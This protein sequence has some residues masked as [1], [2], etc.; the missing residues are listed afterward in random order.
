MQRV[1]LLPQHPLPVK[2]AFFARHGES[3]YSAREL[4]NG[5][6]ARRRSGSPTPASSRRARLGEVLRAEPLD[7]CITTELERVRLT[8][9][10]ALGG[11]DVPRLV[12]ARAERPALRPVR[13]AHD[14]GV[15]GVGDGR[16]VVGDARRR[17]RE[18]VRDRRALRARLPRRARPARG[19]DPRRRA[20][21]ADLVPARRAAKASSRARGRR[22][23]R[24]RP[25]TASRPRSS[26]AASACSRRGS[27]LRLGRARLLTGTLSVVG[28]LERIDEHIR[29][30]DLIE[31]RRRGALPRLGRARLDLPLPRD[32]RARLPR[33][34]AA[35]E[36]LPA[37]RGVRGGRAASAPRSSA[38]T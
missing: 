16:A 7:L 28:V 34:G 12:L 8:A 11:R 27:P 1:A 30:H 36:L 3:E 4:L 14:R 13:G 25:R 6:V 9:D 21:A 18:P 26:S 19:G 20:L 29:R 33:L 32:A 37:R 31:P 35:R 15:P 38:Q 24:T 10:L 5:D 17:R 2:R 23:S 22:S